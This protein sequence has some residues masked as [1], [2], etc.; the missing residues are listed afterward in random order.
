M[1]NRTKLIPPLPETY[2]GSSLAWGLVTL[3][4][5]ELVK[6]GSSGFLASLLKEM[7]NSNNFEKSRSFIE[8]WIEKPFILGHGDDLPG[9]FSN[10]LLARSSRW[11]NLYGNDFG[12]GR[13]VAIKTGANGKSYGIT[14][15]SPGAVG[16]SVDIEIFLPIEVFKAMENDARFMEA[17]SS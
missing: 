12:W 10:M 5:G 7:V 1:N 6:S 4:E 16:G 17:F 2:F 14:I 9:I 11:F 13:P 3:K 15:I 8:S